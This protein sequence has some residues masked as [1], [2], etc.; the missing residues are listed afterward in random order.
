MPNTNLQLDDDYLFRCF[1]GAP[2]THLTPFTAVKAVP[3]GTFLR[4]ANHDMSSPVRLWQ[5]ENIRPLRYNS[6]AEYEE[7]FRHEITQA[8]RVRLRAKGRVFAE[9]SGGLD[10]SSVALVAGE[11][12][13][14]EG[15][16]PEDLQ[17]LSMVY[18]QSRT[19]D[20]RHFIESVEQRR[21]FK[22]NYVSEDELAFHI[23]FNEIRF[24]GLPNPYHLRPGKFARYA[25]Y[26]RRHNA[27]VLLTGIGGDDIFC[28]YPVPEML[29]ADMLRDRRLL[30]AHRCCTTWSSI[31]RVP[32]IALLKR[33]LPFVIKPALAL[34]RQHELA[35]LP[36]WLILDKRRKAFFREVANP[37]ETHISPS[38]AFRT[39]IVQALFRSISLGMWNEYT[40]IYVS[41]PYS[42]RPLVEFCI[43]V[44]M[45]Q[46]QRNGEVRFLQRRALTGVLPSVIAKRR[47]KA[48]IHEPFL[49]AVRRDWH[50]LQDVENWLIC[51]RGYVYA[52]RLREA[53]IQMRG[54]FATSATN[55]VHMA[56]TVERFLRSL[57][58]LNGQSPKVAS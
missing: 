25:S 58:V 13:S 5:P 1:V 47:G 39:G 57:S 32:Y 19:A 21:G 44:P 16:S 12:L 30:M 45:N 23:T 15:K 26:L 35:G 46:M 9:L 38:Q 48:L 22:S 7:Q 3:S 42:H 51:T 50:Y 24:T 6:D 18:E 36:P 11:I 31:S 10:S 17:T 49:R 4:F 27:R 54:G 20:E 52:P 14:S 53:L 40:D 2:P 37:V 33:S 41:H 56:V 55:H 29:V 8:V 43:A 34:N 28:S